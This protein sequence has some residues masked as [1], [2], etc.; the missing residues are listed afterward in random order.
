MVYA[1]SSPK[2][3]KRRDS[4]TEAVHVP[5]SK[6][7]EISRVAGHKNPKTTQRYI[8]RADERTHEAMA[9]LPKLATF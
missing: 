2:L 1:K 7:V 6:V 5:N 4:I 8:H 9:K 3:A